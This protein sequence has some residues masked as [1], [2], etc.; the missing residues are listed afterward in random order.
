M[1]ISKNGRQTIAAFGN[2]LIGG[3]RRPAEPDDRFLLTSIT[4]GITAL[5]IN[6]LDAAAQLDVHAPVAA[7]LPAFAQNGKE[8][9]TPAQILTHT[10]GL[11]PA[12]NTAERDEVGL[13]A[14]AHRRAAHNARLVSAPGER[15]S[16]S[17][18]GWWVLGELIERASGI[19]ADEHL[20]AA[21]AGPLGMT[22]TR[23]EIGVDEPER[24]AR[25]DAPGD[26]SHHEHA[27][28][29]G[30]PSGGLVSNATDLL[31]LGEA[32]AAKLHK[33]IKRVQ[34][35]TVTGEWQGVPVRWGLGWELGGPST[36]WP[37]DTLFASGASGTALWIDPESKHIAVLLTAS[38][39]ADRKQ[40]ATFGDLA[41]QALQ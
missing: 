1:A 27:R 30:Y 40:L 9:V 21:I 32:A 38:W 20:G 14:A 22:A 6:L 31:M 11:D 39:Q 26:Q 17:S 19:P 16:Y 3:A 41:A 7:T 24:Y 28:I 18:P 5:Q 33:A 8:T 15:F 25:R 36:R 35:T 34:G 10:A 23:Y 13:G 12:A 29:A 37:P 2:L 4:K